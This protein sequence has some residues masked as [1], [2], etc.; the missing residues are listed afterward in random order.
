M[1]EA[2]EFSIMNCFAVLLKC[3]LVLNSLYKPWFAFLVP[4]LEVV[5]EFCLMIC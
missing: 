5:N 2:V 3:V 1:L 4:V